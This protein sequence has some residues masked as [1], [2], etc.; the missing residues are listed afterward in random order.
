MQ[1]EILLFGIVSDVIG[2]RSLKMNVP[3]AIT[4]EDLRSQLSEKY[5]KL[6]NY[7]SFSV[8]VN[9]EYV[10]DTYELKNTDTIALIPP[11]SGG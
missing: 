7:K 5:P 6:A 1:L 8:A 10:D 9:M 4:I 2:Q 11:V 3:V